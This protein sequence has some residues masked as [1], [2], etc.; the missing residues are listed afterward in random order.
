MGMFTV[1]LHYGNVYSRMG[2]WECLQENGIMGTFTVEWHYGNVYS[3][4]L[5]ECLQ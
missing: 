5:W 4:A 1:E 2:L 3:R